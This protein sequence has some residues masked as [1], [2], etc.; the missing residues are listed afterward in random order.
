MEK[1]YQILWIEFWA[2]EE[3]IKNYRNELSHWDKS[4]NN[5]CQGLQIGQI[6]QYKDKIK[7]YFF[8]NY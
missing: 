7:K 2:S 5:I 3:E 6:I 4:F 8:K 1:Y